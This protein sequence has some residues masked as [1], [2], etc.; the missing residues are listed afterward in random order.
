VN[1]A[2]QRAKLNRL[3]DQVDDLKDSAHVLFAAAEAGSPLEDALQTALLHL[4]GAKASLGQARDA[5]GGGG[6]AS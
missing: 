5:L 1:A 3:R 4:A 6:R 2:E